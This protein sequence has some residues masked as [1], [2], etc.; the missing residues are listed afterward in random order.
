MIKTV[1]ILGRQPAISVAELESKFG[2]ES[3]ESIDKNIAY[4][5]IDADSIQINQLGGVVKL[6]NVITDLSAHSTD[7]L[8]QGIHRYI[9]AAPREEN[10][11][12]QL[13]ISTYNC[14][15]RIDGMKIALKI[16]NLLR[17][18][19][20]S[21]RVVP[22]VNGQISTAQTIHN[23]LTK[24][25]NFEMQITHQNNKFYVAQIIT[26]QDIEAYT[27]RDQARPKRDARV[28]MLPPKLAQIIINLAQ[29]KHAVLD[30]FCGTGVI[31]QEAAL[32]G[33]Q[34]YGT[35][36]EPR[37]IDYSQTNVNQWLRKQH[38]EID[39]NITLEVGDATSHAWRAAPFDS[40]ATETY[41]GRA[42]STAPSPSELEQNLKTVELIHK[43]F[44]ENIAKQTKT[45]FRL[46][47]AVPAWFI[48]N[49]TVHLKTLDSLE[50]IG[51]NRV[52]FV[53]ANNDD[54]I[55]H[56]EGQIVGRELVTLIRK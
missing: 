28:G 26:V 19:A 2:S 55:Y 50:R 42:Y 14:G 22:S 51:Y 49:R 8:A 4:L 13:G 3:I 46:C 36:I 34:V 47:I 45:G 5:N 20:I 17:N 54:L 12:L 11:K 1:A 44:L 35:D 27:A 7:E 37:M 41:L 40:I 48:G 9:T 32:V 23:K 43:K 29:P 25:G 52:S 53:H 21:A 33:K 56:R 10:K 15:N 16:K 31:L 24:P 6:G 38:P 18:T 30:P 39:I